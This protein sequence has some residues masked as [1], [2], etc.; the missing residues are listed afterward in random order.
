MIKKLAL[1]SIAALSLIMVTAQAEGPKCGG[2]KC[3]TGMMKKANM[4]K[5]N[6]RMHSPFLIKH[7]LPHYTKMIMKSWD[8]PKLALTQEQKTKLLEVRKETIG[9]IAALK[10]QIMSLTKTIVQASKAGTKASELKTKVEKLA[11][12]EAEATM[13]HLKCIDNTKA[14]LKP[15]QFAYLMEK[16]K[17]QQKMKKGMKCASGKCG[18]K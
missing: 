14:V 13:T 3:G 1:T 5:K 6:K 11:A 8:D 10:P 9:S 12:L 2:G 7:G 4:V 17:A 16:R 18:S 15:E